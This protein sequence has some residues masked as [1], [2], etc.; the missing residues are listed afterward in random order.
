M[1]NLKYILILSLILSCSN[2]KETKV[3]LLEKAIS[4]KKTKKIDFNINSIPIAFSAKTTK[5]TIFNSTNN[6]GKYWV[7]FVY[8]NQYLVKEKIIL[9]LNST[10]NKYK[11]QV[12]FIGIID[13]FIETQSEFDAILKNSK[14]Q[15][16]QID[17]TVSYNKEVVLNHNVVCLP[18]KIIIDPSGKVIY[19][20]CGGNV[21]EIINNKLDQALKYNQ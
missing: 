16:E 15:F 9:E 5:N 8:D 6:K 11:D 21:E 10:F 4:E 7:V 1:K 13:G 14:M 17:N 18:T 3:K 12:N 2:K 19:N 20:G